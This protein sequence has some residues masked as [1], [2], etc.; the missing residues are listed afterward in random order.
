[1]AAAATANAQ[2]SSSGGGSG[3]MSTAMAASLKKGPWT[4]AEDA[5]L[6]EYVKKH[7]EGN[8][9]AVQKNSGL[10][11]CGKSCRLRWANHLRPNLKKGSFSPEEERLI[12]HL[13]AKLGNKWARMAAQLPG[14]T[15]NE[16]K[17]YWN[18]RI[19]RRQRAGL[20]L[21]PAEM[22]RQ[23]LSH[24]TRPLNCDGFAPV[25][26][27]PAELQPPLAFDCLKPLNPQQQRQPPPPPL[28]FDHPKPRP[29]FESSNSPQILNCDCYPLP[30]QMP[31]L[32]RFSDRAMSFS[33]RASTLSH[34]ALAAAPAPAPGPLSF[35][36]MGN[37]GMA[38]RLMPQLRGS[39][40]GMEFCGLSEPSIPFN[41]GGS[42]SFSIKMELPSSQYAESVSSNTGSG[43]P[44]SGGGGPSPMEV[45]G[46]TAEPLGQSNSGLLDA[47]LLGTQPMSGCEESGTPVHSQS[48]FWKNLPPPPQPQVMPANSNCKVEWTA[49][50]DTILAAPSP[51]TPCALDDSS[52]AQSSMGMNVKLKKEEMGEKDGNRMEEEEELSTLLDFSTPSG[53]PP[54]AD[55]YSDSTEM[56]NAQSGVTDSPNTVVFEEDMGLEMR[57]LTS[58][59]SSND[60]IWALGSYA[61]NNLPGIC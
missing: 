4:S 5:I 8:W 16:I 1:M 3:G 2:E 53:A 18:T 45:V 32:K 40:M 60:Q 56:S 43:A 37:F 9:N 10:S 50:E 42:S 54:I 33:A 36:Q 26:A 22:Q 51:A 34:V 49:A 20:P 29:F 15:D 58:S 55:W 57:H 17:N 25:S 19:K 39:D 23:V 6:V 11:R 14:R 47:L 21:Y 61:W 27:K 7:G 59:L 30:S 48:N 35:R 46:P 31:H 24:H 44:P 28:C 38:R 52:S 41:N 12:L 13:H